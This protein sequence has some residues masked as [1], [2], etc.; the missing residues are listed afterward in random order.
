MSE[1]PT[2]PT[3]WQAKVLSY[4]KHC[5]IF[6]GGPRGN[7][8][9]VVMCFDGLAHCVEA[10]FASGLILRESHAGTAEIM[11]RFF[12]MATIAFGNSV[13]M[14]KSDGVVSM[15]NGATMSFS[16]VSDADS[17]ARRTVSAGGT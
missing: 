3:E 13:S 14:N 15:P 17:Y 6:N 8:K 2:S 4:R 5:N 1:I 9:S 11:L 16:N 12:Q 7:G 10:P